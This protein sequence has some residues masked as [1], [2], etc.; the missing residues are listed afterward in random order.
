M[1]KLDKAISLLDSI[2]DSIK[3]ATYLDVYYDSMELLYEFKKELDDYLE[4]LNKEE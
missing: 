3:S 4:K 2:E 1:L